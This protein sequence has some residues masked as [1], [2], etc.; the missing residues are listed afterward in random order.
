MDETFNI[1]KSYY[2]ND[3]VCTL[4]FNLFFNNNIEHNLLVLYI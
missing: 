4:K 3:H 1:L 2:N